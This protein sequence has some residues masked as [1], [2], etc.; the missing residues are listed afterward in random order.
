MIY[1]RRKWVKKGQTLGAVTVTQERSIYV[2]LDKTRLDGLKS[3]LTGRPSQPCC[4]YHLRAAFH[5]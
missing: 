4:P 2:T 1:T 5:G 3:R